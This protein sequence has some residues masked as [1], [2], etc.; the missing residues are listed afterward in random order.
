VFFFFFSTP[1]SGGHIN[2]PPR[3][4]W[5]ITEPLPQDTRRIRALLG[6]IVLA[7]SVE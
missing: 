2:N 1:F 3:F 5:L 6:L 4:L 7:M